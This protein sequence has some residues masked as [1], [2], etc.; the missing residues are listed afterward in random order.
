MGRLAKLRPPPAGTFSG[1]GPKP[2]SATPPG[3][4]RDFS[5]G[6]ESAFCGG[7]GAGY[8]AAGTSPTRSRQTRQGLLN[9]H[10]LENL[11]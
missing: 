3:G 5:P 2:G 11:Y 9:P 7:A 10:F 6:G 1:G 8:P 4:L